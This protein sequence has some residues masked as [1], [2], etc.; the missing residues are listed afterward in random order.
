MHAILTILKVQI[1]DSVIKVIC[2]HSHLISAAQV[3][4]CWRRLTARSSGAC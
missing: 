1:E 2:P 4:G 3:P